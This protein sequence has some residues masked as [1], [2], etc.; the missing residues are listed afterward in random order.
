MRE[1]TFADQRDTMK[2]PRTTTP[3][4]DFPRLFVAIP[5]PSKWVEAL[6][7]VGSKSRYPREVRFLPAENLHVTACFIGAVAKEQVIEVTEKLVSLCARLLPFALTFEEVRPAPNRN[8]PKMVW[9]VFVRHPQF[10]SLVSSLQ[11]D[12]RPF[13]AKQEDRPDPIP[14]ITL[15]RIK[16]PVREETLSLFVPSTPE[17]LSVDR[18]ELWE[19]FLSSSGAAY[20]KRAEFSLGTK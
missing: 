18:V 6:A 10:E 19:S 4:S 8:R 17:E 16:R 20:M 1:T 9:A 11:M 15:A 5:L 7:L 13:I 12:L 2:N 3:D 14:H